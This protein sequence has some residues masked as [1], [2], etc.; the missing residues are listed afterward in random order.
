MLLSINNAVLQ[1]RCPHSFLYFQCLLLC[2]R[3]SWVTV[4]ECRWPTKL[5]HTYYLAIYRKSLLTPD[6]DD[7]SFDE[8]ALGSV[9][10]I[11]HG[12]RLVQFLRDESKELD[13][14]IID[15]MIFWANQS[16]F[17]A[18]TCCLLSLAFL[19]WINVVAVYFSQYQFYYLI[20]W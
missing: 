18:S 20:T 14:G 9:N 12:Q 5:K 13:W 7:F 15:P 16:S 8:I 4:A 3:N 17:K 10:E 6:W 1:E 19:F 2:Y 11:Q